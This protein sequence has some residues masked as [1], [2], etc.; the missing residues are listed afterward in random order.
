MKIV[1]ERCGRLSKNPE[2]CSSCGAPIGG[3]DEL[4]GVQASAE[5]GWAKISIAS[6]PPNDRSRAIEVIQN[7]WAGIE[8]FTVL[9]L[10][11]SQASALGF[12]TSTASVLVRRDLLESL[13]DNA[14]QEVASIAVAFT[15]INMPVNTAW[16]ANTIIDLSRRKLSELQE[17][18]QK[19]AREIKS[20]E[21]EEVQKARKQI[22]SIAQHVGLPVKELIAGAGEKP[23]ADKTSAVRVRYRNPADSQQTWTGRGRQPRWVADALA[24]GKTLDELNI[25]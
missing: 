6:V 14:R 20:R 11:Q 21:Q 5:W 13:V 24:Q 22:L 18:Q 8:G 4:A 7:E 1:C 10:L 9:R 3:D 2:I 12:E 17:L 23:K 15:P 19:I 25:Q 16:E